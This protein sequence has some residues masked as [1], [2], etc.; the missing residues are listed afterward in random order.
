M[1]THCTLTFIALLSY[2]VVVSAEVL[3]VSEADV[4]QTDHNG[5]DQHHEREHGGRRVEA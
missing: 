5:D 4:R 3:E 1:F 2:L